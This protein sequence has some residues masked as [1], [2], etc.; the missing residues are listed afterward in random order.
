MH[1]KHQDQIIYFNLYY[2]YYRSSNIN[3]SKSSLV[4]VVRKLCN[5]YEKRLY[6][7][8]SFFKIMI[9]FCDSVQKYHMM[10]KVAS[11]LRTFSLKI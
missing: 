8:K 6:V 1:T 9:K 11:Y 2:V 3:N 7:A 10:L 5:K 4:F